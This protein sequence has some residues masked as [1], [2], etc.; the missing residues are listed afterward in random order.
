MKLIKTDS[1][2]GVGISYRS[3]IE[4][5][6]KY[7][8]STR[9]EITPFMSKSNDSPNN[10][11]EGDMIDIRWCYNLYHDNVWVYRIQ[12]TTEY[13]IIEKDKQIDD[14]N[15]L[16]E[17]ERSFENMCKELNKQKIYYPFAAYFTTPTRD[18]EVVEKSI[19]LL[20]LCRVDLNKYLILQ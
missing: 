16:L 8:G 3:D 4:E 15:I 19:S 17:I 13:L 2:S 1:V 10:K 11:N 18:A 14:D 9:F 20:Q 7:L 5:K 6:F 12:L